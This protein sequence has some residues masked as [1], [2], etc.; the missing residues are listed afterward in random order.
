MFFCLSR[1]TVRVTPS[2]RQAAVGAFGDEHSGVDQ[3]GSGYI[4]V[5]QGVRLAVSWV[6]E[7]G[8][9]RPFFA[10]QDRLAFPETKMEPEEGP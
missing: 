6:D 5:Q 9:E 4:F 10:T 2:P 8:A 1:A 3:S 7:S